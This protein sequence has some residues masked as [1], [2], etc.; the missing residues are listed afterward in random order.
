MNI[1]IIILGQIY[2]YICMLEFKRFRINV[3]VYLSTLWMM[4]VFPNFHL[5]LKDLKIEIHLFKLIKLTIN[6]PV[7]N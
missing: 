6:N 1:V 4:M 7:N 5:H 2:Y 3:M